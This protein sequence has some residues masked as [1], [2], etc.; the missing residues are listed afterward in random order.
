MERVRV[1]IR[2]RVQGV[3]FRYFTCAQA[4]ELGL[5]GW[6]RNLASGEVEAEFEGQESAIETV[7]VRCRRGPALA[8][9][10]EV[11]ELERAP[12][13]EARHTGFAMRS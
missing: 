7:L 2:G 10:L 8:R 9:V 1:L 4:R 6:V 12:V 13:D 5:G 11:R 3:G